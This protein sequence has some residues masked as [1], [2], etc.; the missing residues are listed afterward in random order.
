MS[1][2]VISTTQPSIIQLYANYFEDIK[3][4]TGPFTPKIEITQL[5][6]TAELIDVG[7]LIKPD[8]C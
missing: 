1:L 8:N 3:K 7:S 4:N 2:F 5:V 6:S